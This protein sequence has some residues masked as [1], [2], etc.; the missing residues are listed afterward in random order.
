MTKILVV[1]DE[2]GIALGLKNDLV[3]EGYEVEIAG[4]GQMALERGRSGSFDLIVLDLMLPK[5]DGFTVCR[6]LRQAG[7]RTPIL[8]LTAKALEAEKILGFELGADDYV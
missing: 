1:E 2:P 6:E 8:M 4:D 7:N 5:K 3:L